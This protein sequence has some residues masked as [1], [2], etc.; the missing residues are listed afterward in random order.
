VKSER[1]RNSLRRRVC[2]GGQQRRK[3]RLAGFSMAGAHRDAEAALIILERACNILRRI[4]PVLNRKPASN[5]RDRRNARVRR[6]G[7]NLGEASKNG[8]KLRKLTLNRW[9]YVLQLLRKNLIQHISG[10]RGRM[11]WSGACRTAKSEGNEKVCAA[12]EPRCARQRRKARGSGIFYFGCGGRQ[13]KMT[14]LGAAAY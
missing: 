4:N 14:L 9:F 6:G 1:E 3:A 2:A 12:R 8:G 13:C 5:R 10:G 7:A 11:A